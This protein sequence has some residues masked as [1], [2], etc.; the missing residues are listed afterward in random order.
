L[1]RQ[2]VGGSAN[3]ANGIH[4]RA[5]DVVDTARQWQHFGMAN[6]PTKYQSIRAQR[7]IAAG[8]GN[9]DAVVCRNIR[10]IHHVTQP[11]CDSRA[12]RAQ[13]GNQS[14]GDDQAVIV[15]SLQRRAAT[16]HIRYFKNPL[17]PH[18]AVPRGSASGNGSS[19]AKLMLIDDCV[20]VV[21]SANMDNT[22]WY[23]AG[24]TNL[25]LFNPEDVKTLKQR[26]FDVC[27]TIAEPVH[28]I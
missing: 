19:H 2:R 13:G 22:S 18:L 11:E 5:H 9:A 7:F 17:H 14:W 6:T 16:L 25:A 24:E 23:H 8:A 26:I 28:G 15:Q 4:T 10:N 21:G 27:W 20:A 3:F 1:E 12:Q